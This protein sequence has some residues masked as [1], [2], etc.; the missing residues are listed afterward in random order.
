MDNKEINKLEHLKT[1]EIEY[2]KIEQYE[3]SCRPLTAF[4][5]QT[6]SVVVA[7][8]RFILTTFFVTTIFGILS[9]LTG[10]FGIMFKGS[11]IHAVILLLLSPIPIAMLAFMYY[12]IL[13]ILSVPWT[14]LVSFLVKRNLDFDYHRDVGEAV[15]YNLFEGLTPNCGSE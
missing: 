13:A 11:I 14:M 1:L 3:T 4:D 9:V 5:L 2:D 10:I 15:L 6:D 12:V 7:C 8:T